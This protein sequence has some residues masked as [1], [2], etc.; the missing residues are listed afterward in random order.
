M[1]RES[2]FADNFTRFAGLRFCSS[3]L[4]LC[5]PLGPRVCDKQNE[6]TTEGTEYLENFRNSSFSGAVFS[7]FP[8]VAFFPAATL[9]IQL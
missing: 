7:V 3:L 6:L 9:L 2:V 1:I 5:S 8:V 4:A